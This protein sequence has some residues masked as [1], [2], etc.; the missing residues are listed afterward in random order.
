MF[1]PNFVNVLLQSSNSSIIIIDT[2]TIIMPVDCK[3]EEYADSSVTV[4]VKFGAR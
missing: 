2:K 1:M 4:W 3:I